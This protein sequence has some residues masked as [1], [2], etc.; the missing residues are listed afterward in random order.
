MHTLMPVTSPVMQPGDDYIRYQ[1]GHTRICQYKHL[2]GTASVL[3]P[4]HGAAIYA[5]RHHARPGQGDQLELHKLA[6][7]MACYPVSNR[8][9]P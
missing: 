2:M 9:S 8:N 1:C 6:S 5:T 7:A 3:L 4:K